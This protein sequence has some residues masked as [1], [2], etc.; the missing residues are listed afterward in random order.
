MS[1]SSAAISEAKLRTPSR[2]AV[3]ERLLADAVAGDRQLPAAG[4]PEREGEHA[5]EAADAVDA[6]LL[7]EVDDDLGVALGGEAMAAGD[8][9]G[10]QLG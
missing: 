9:L 8:E 3:E 5:V 7:V 1:A 2:S 6:V 10:A 4:V